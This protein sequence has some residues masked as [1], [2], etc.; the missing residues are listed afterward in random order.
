[1]TRIADIT[2]PTWGRRTLL[3]AALLVGAIGVARGEPGFRQAPDALLEGE[4]MAVAYSGFREGQHPDRG[5]G[6]VNP[7]PQEI[8]EDLRILERAGFRLIRL[9]DAGDNSRVTLELIREHRLPLKVLLGM[10]LSAELSNHEGCPWL[11]EPIPAATLAANTVANAAEIERGIA[12]ANAYPEIV[13]AVNVG[14]EALVDWNDHM[15][16]VE[17]VIAYVRQVKG[18]I[19]QP[20][21]VADNYVWWINEGAALAREL[22]FVGVHTYPQWEGKTIDEALAYTIENVEGVHAA[23]P[24]SRLAVLEAGWATTAVEFGDRAGEAMQ[25]RYYEELRAWATR[26]NTTVFF[27]EAFDE[28]WK[29]DPGSPLG[30]EKHWGLYFVD[31]TPKQAMR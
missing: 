22:D 24:D 12:L 17:G 1:M 13:V 29:G 27:F 26:T 5:A 23:L 4:V 2:R 18:R 16:S 19:A 6:A 20:V 28:P 7:S 9:Y 8:L 10:W 25:Q 31:R 21:T 3:L 11:T 14:N 30:A 15:M